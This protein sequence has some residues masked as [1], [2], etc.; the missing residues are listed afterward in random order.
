MPKTAETPSL[1]DK[2][3]DVINRFVDAAKQINRRHGMWVEVNRDLIREGEE[4]V[5]Q[6]EASKNQTETKQE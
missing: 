6:L 1:I 2:A 3:I 4:V 5:K